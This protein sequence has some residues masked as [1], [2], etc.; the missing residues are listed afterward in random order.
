MSFLNRVKCDHCGE[1][2]NLNELK[3]ND[4]FKIDIKSCRYLSVNILNIHI[5]KECLE[6][7]LKNIK[8]LISEYMI[9]NDF[10]EFG[11]FLDDKEFLEWLQVPCDNL[12][13]LRT[14]L[15]TEKNALL[16]A[17]N[18]NRLTK[19]GEGQVSLIN[20]ILDMF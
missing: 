2:L 13:K 4:F 18:E 16:Q 12:H 17:K 6:N 11:L 20:I 14:Y 1:E 10:E 15:E 19:F 8:V 5:C 3:K 7:Y 9:K